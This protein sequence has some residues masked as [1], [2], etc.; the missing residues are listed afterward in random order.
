MFSRFLAS[1]WRSFGH[2]ECCLPP[3]HFDLVLMD[4][5]CRQQQSIYVF[6]KQFYRGFISLFLSCITCG[7]SGLAGYLFLKASTGPLTAAQ[8]TEQF[9]FSYTSGVSWIVTL[10]Q[11]E[12]FLQ[13]ILCLLTNQHFPQFQ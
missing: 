5:A 9:I 13:L 1:V 7:S 3:F 8:P 10:N 12:F 11:I 6:I 4:A 2:F